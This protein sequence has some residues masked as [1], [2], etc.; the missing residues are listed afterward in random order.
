[1][2]IRDDAI[3]IMRQDLGPGFEA[4]TFAVLQRAYLRRALRP[5]LKAL[6]LSRVDSTALVV[7]RQALEQALRNEETLVEAER[8]G[9]ERLLD[10]EL[11]T[12]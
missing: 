10:T 1:M 4:A 2:A 9:T 5:K 11:D 12:L 6:Y 8:A 3:A 7:A